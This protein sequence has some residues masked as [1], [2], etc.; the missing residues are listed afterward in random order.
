M[1]YNYKDT[2]SLRD[3]IGTS[4]NI[5]IKTDVMDKSPS[6]ISP[7]HV[8]EKDKAIYKRRIFSICRPY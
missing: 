8:E 5:E 1:L 7:Y 4:P 6:F 2:F 3:E